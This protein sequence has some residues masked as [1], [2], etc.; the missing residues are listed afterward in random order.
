MTATQATVN[1]IRLYCRQLKPI[2]GH[3]VPNLH[4][5]W[6][7]ENV[8]G[9]REGVVL[10]VLEDVGLGLGDRS[11]LDMDDLRYVFPLAF[12]LSSGK[13]AFSFLWPVP[14]KNLS[15]PCP[16]QKLPSF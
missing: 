6:Y 7:G 4:Q 8:E 12:D 9:E 16:Q 3:V 14:G 2:Q 15:F 5:V 13:N 10:L 1:E 11:D